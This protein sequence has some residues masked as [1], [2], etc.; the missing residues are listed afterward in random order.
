VLKSQDILVL[1][2]LAAGAPSWTFDSLARQLTLSPSA[3]HRSLERAAAAGLYDS[4]RRAIK[5][6]PLIEFL[7]H[8]LPYVFP[9]QWAGEARG[10]ATAW[11]APP[12]SKQIVPSSN[13]PVWPDA[14][15]DTRGI[16]LT[17]LHPSVP[18]ATRDDL[19]LREL[20]TLADAI[21]IGNARERRI[22]GDELK[23]RLNGVWPG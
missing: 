5:R 20:L 23:K 7:C 11:A 14:V 17:P 13:P 16:A 12:L 21:R 8:G 1:L 9:P 15:G 2:K 18:G 19:R 3:V 22:A 6:A 4:R 10:V